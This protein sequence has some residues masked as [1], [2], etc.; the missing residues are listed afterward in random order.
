MTIL[1]NALTGIVI[2]LSAMGSTEA[3][4]PAPELTQVAD[5]KQFT[6]E[7]NTDRSGND[8]RVVELLA[9]DGVAQCEKLCRL[10]SACVSFTFVKQSTTVPRP[11]CRLKD[12][13][14]FGHES[15]CCTSGT[16]QR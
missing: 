3:R 4:G 12:A 13:A 11:V 10:A 7:P 14:P 9:T 6:R 1:L 8:I 2:G 15:S 16:L 5:R